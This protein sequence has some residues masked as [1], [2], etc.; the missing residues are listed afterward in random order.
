MLAD[1]LRR[2]AAQAL[3]DA[4]VHGGFVL[5]LVLELIG[6]AALAARAPALRGPR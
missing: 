4:V 2:E 5:V 6:F 3:P 1:V